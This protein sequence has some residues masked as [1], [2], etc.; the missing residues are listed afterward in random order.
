MIVIERFDR[1]GGT[2]LGFEDMPVLM[3]KTAD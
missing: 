2:S 1:M 3:G